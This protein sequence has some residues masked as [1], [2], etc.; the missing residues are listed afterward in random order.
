MNGR[1][2]H[3]RIWALFKEMTEEDRE[4]FLRSAEEVGF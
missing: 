2:L 4:E 1:K 3:A